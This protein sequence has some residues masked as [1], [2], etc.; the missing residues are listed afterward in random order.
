MLDKKQMDIL[1]II[2]DKSIEPE[3]LM[4]EIRAYYLNKNYDKAVL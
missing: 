1:E 4:N 2:N 3:I